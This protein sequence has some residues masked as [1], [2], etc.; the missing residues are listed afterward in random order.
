MVFPIERWIPAEDCIQPLG[1]SRVGERGRAGGCAATASMPGHG[2]RLDG[3]RDGDRLPGGARCF[4]G[5]AP[6]P[7]PS[8]LCVRAECQRRGIQREPPRTVLRAGPCRRARLA[9][10]NAA[11]YAPGAGCTQHPSARTLLPGEVH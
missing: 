4:A 5:S 8:G 9:A 2:N 11:D 10:P 7:E 3:C 1:R 6:A